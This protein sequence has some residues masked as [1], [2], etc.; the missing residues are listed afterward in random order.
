MSELKLKRPAPPDLDFAPPEC[1][2]CE[3]ET[4]YE[5]GEFYCS[6][7]EVAWDRS[8]HFVTWYDDGPG[9]A[10]V[11]EWWNSSYLPLQ[12]E[13]IRHT[14]TRCIL[15]EDHTE[16]H[17]DFDEWITWDDNDPRIV[18]NNNEEDAA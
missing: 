15:G 4:T 14:K 5:D 7:C 9:C 6:D 8:G 12:Y 17:R 16:K 10:S 18:N 13:A 3:C 1:T 2:I 11:I